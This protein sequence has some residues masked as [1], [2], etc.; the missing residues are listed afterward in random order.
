MGCFAPYPTFLDQYGLVGGFVE[1]PKP[2][3]DDGLMM[4]T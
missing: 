3:D 1:R 2:P 4:M